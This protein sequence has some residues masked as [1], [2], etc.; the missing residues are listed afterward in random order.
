MVRH[1]IFET[2][3]LEPLGKIKDLPARISVSAN[4]IVY[5][6]LHRALLVSRP[7]ADRAPDAVSG[8]LDF[9]V[10]GEPEM[11]PLFRVRPQQACLRFDIEQIVTVA[12]ARE[13]GYRVSARQHLVQEFP[14]NRDEVIIGP[15]PRH[16]PI[17]QAA[18]GRPDGKHDHAQGKQKGQR[19]EYP[20][21]HEWGNSFTVRRWEPLA[22]DW[23]SC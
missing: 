7:H 9:K 23:H 1:D 15:V 4:R 5:L 20:V 16:C 12:V 11:W 8:E 17:R 13:F 10:A 2:E 21:F 19:E 18:N 22:K 6:G 14:L 3:I